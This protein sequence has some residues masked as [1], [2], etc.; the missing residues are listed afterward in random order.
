MSK[1][2]AGFGSGSGSSGAGGANKPKAAGPLGAAVV[3]A[4]QAQAAAE[5]QQQHSM[6]AIVNSLPSS[7]SHYS[8]FSVSFWFFT[9][10]KLSSVRKQHEICPFL[11]NNNIE[12]DNFFA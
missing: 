5:K 3:A 6:A 7:G 11:E 10:S 4:A 8:K 9:R 2:L 12:P 1:A